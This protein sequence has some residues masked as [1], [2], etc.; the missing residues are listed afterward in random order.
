MS[1]AGS[2]GGDAVAV[3]G[4]IGSTF[5]KL[6]RVDSGGAVQGQTRLP[7]THHDISGAVRRGLCTLSPGAGGG[8]AE[9]DGLALCSSAAGGLRIVVLGFEHTLTVE[10]GLRTS[11]TAGGRV[12][13]V[14]GRHD[15][16]P[17]KPPD[18]LTLAPDVALL[19][20][21]TDGGD[22]ESI[23]RAGEALRSAAPALPIVVAGNQATYP[24]LRHILGNNRPVHYVDNVMPR[25]GELSSAAAQSAIRRIFIEHVIGRGRFASGSAIADRVR[26]PTPAAVLSA[27]ELVAGLGSEDPILARPV[28][29]DVGGATTDVY[30]VIPSQS[31][32]GY[33]QR[34][35]PDQVV[36]R[37][38]E[39]D[40]GLREGATALLQVAKREAH[41]DA[42][43][44]EALAASVW[45]RCRD[46]GFLPDTE[47]EAAVD[48]RL[49]TIATALALRRHA[50]VLRAAVSPGGVSLEKTGRDLRAA[51]CLVLTGGIYQHTQRPEE[52]AR[53]AITMARAHGAL[54]HDVPI[55]RDR[56]YLL[57]AAGLL[58]TC[59]PERARS[60]VKATLESV[61]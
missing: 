10:A 36:T 55:L 21:G 1:Q 35:V 3:L 14:Y 7:T 54:V 4:D 26:M 38:V 57:W 59:E 43:E 24:K 58:G 17:D 18:V 20:G 29:V 52:L 50:G 28:I 49:A 12:V 34:S 9:I 40:L 44:A 15:F 23:L 2:G 32:R 42:A 61:G 46:R 27:A 37:T 11:A 51:S 41:I 13:G 25:I 39:G 6:V 45:R 31:E 22:E 56:G 48:E 60:M 19:T 30:S 33:V 53:S 16:H 5:V 47:E 8:A